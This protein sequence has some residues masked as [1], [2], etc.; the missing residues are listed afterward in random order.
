MDVTDKKHCLERP[1]LVI[2]PMSHPCPSRPWTM[3]TAR[4]KSTAQV[5][6]LLQVALPVRLM[7]T[8]HVPHTCVVFRFSRGPDFVFRPREVIGG[9]VCM[10]SFHWPIYMIYDSH[11]PITMSGSMSRWV[12][13]RPQAHTAPA[14]HLWH[15]P[16]ELQDSAFYP[17]V[18][19]L[20]KPYWCWTIWQP[21]ARPC[22]PMQ[23]VA[24]PLIFADHAS[25]VHVAKRHLECRII[26]DVYYMY[27]QV[28]TTGVVYCGNGSIGVKPW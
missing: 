10:A 7:A 25:A 24:P 20:M 6:M 16:C 13:A 12:V 17:L 8:F 3:W 14:P 11:W 28:S 21:I 2:I 9:V 23:T 1:R 27:Y 26:Y 5:P 19:V 22:C 15:K 4:P 18:Q